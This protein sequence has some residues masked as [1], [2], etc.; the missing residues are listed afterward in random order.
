VQTD[1]VIRT[2]EKHCRTPA[3]LE[4]VDRQHI[5]LMQSAAPSVRSRAHLNPVHDV[6]TSALVNCPRAAPS[7][8]P[9]QEPPMTWQWIGLTAFSLTLLPSGVAMAVGRAPRWPRA[10]QT[11]VPTCGWALLLICATA[12]LNTVP[13]LVGASADVTLAGTVAGGVLALAGCSLLGF[14]TGA[15]RH[16]PAA[17]LHKEP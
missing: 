8:Y 10:R 2:P 12:P 11:S 13:R 5:T 4:P 3:V 9:S 1:H 14:A 17:A 16:R 15:N 7:A 6:F